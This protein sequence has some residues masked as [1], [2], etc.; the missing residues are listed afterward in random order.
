MDPR[1]RSFWF[2]HIQEVQTVPEMMRLAWPAA[3][4][5]VTIMVMSLAAGAFLVARQWPRPS[6]AV[7]TTA[8]C[9]VVA[10]ITAYLTWRMQDY[11]C[12]IGLPALGAAASWICERRLANRMAPSI[13]AVLVLAPPIVATMICASV[14]AISGPHKGPPDHASHC[15]NAAAYGPLAKLPPGLV[16]ATQD[17]GPFILALTPH[18][19]IVAPYH[20]LSSQILAVH[21]A[22]DARPDQAEALV[23][24]LRPDYLVTC[25]GYP[26]F[27][28]AGSFAER[29]DAAPPAWLVPLSAPRATIRIYR[30]APE[31]H[32]A[33]MK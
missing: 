21:Q 28:S 24:R 10:A 8:L 7:L 30:I 3:V 9:L 17:L 5:A 1:V 16:M 20:R 13:A 22:F 31:V 14:N 18:S 6:T 11:V 23:R 27:V 32:A 33:A 4:T 26:L 25:P 29:V 2:D 15:Y 19:V 12:W